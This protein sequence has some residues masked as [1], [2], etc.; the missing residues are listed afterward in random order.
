[1]LIWLRDSRPY[2]ANAVGGLYPRLLPSHPQVRRCKSLRPERGGERLAMPGE[3][4]IKDF[5]RYPRHGLLRTGRAG[6]LH[7]CASHH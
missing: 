1:M 7:L 5:L 3:F 6:H 2:N 4:L